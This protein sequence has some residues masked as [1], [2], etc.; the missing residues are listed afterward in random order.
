MHHRPRSAYLPADTGGYLPD[1]L[2]VI[3]DVARPAIG[4][5]LHGGVRR[6]A[7][8]RGRLHALVLLT[9]GSLVSG[10]AGGGRSRPGWCS[11]RPR[12]GLANP[13]K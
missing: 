7:V 8:G 6:A 4:W 10:S 3:V 9:G 5:D 12:Q 11:S 1:Y 2:M 13:G